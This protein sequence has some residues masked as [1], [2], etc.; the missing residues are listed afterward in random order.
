MKHRPVLYSVYVTEYTLYIYAYMLL[1]MLT[2]LQKVSNDRI[3]AL[4]CCDY[5]ILLS[6]TLSTRPA[7]TSLIF[8]LDVPQRYRSRS[9]STLE[10]SKKLLQDGRGHLSAQSGGT[11]TSSLLYH[12]HTSSNC[13]MLWT[14][15]LSSR[16]VIVQSVLYAPCTCSCARVLHISS[17]IVSRID[18]HRQCCLIRTFLDSFKKE[19]VNAKG[20]AP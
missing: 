16:Q 11:G 7:S 1:S 18:L 6:G 10:S 9:T 19:A 8:S 3:A 15:K 4:A 2:G 17:Q 12:F 5:F 14:P 20:G 13:N